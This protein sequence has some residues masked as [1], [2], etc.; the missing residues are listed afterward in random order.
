MLSLLILLQYA[1]VWGAG[2]FV[3]SSN[4]FRIQDAP[5]FP[6]SKVAIFPVELRE[7]REKSRL[8]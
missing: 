6:V 5:E 3:W 7:K 8:M 4:K 1:S 2:S